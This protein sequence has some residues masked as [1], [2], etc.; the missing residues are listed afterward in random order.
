MRKTER[1]GRRRGGRGG[2]PSAPHPLLCCRGEKHHVYRKTRA[3]SLCEYMWIRPTNPRNIYWQGLT[4]IPNNT[5]WKAHA[6]MFAHVRTHTHTPT[7]T[8]QT[9]A[10]TT[11]DT[12]R[13]TH[14]QNPS[15]SAL[16]STTAVLCLHPS[17]LPPL[18]PQRAHPPRA[19]LPYQACLCNSDSVSR[20]HLAQSLLT[21]T[22]TCMQTQTHTHG[23]PMT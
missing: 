14:V 2:P 3:K 17:L 19:C 22:P 5:N 4:H 20:S 10:Q 9:L 12:H 23:E 7:I 18:T 8:M 6:N 11:K 21:H 15:V 13:Q 16:L 1:G